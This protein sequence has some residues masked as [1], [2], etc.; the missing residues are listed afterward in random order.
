MQRSL[1]CLT[2]LVLLSIPA[3]SQAREVVTQWEYKSAT[4]CEGSNER[5]DLKKLGE[6]G[7]ELVSVNQG[8]SSGSSTGCNKYYFK[9]PR[10]A[11][12]GQTQTEQ[13]VAP[14]C[15]LS[16]SQIL[17]LRGIRI[18]MSAD[19]LLAL[20]PGS[21]DQFRIKYALDKA[22]L[23]PNYGIA[24]LNFTPQEYPELKDRFANVRS[25]D[26]TLFD[27]RVS[28]F[29]VSYEFHQ[30]DQA[31]YGWT[32]DDWIAKLSESLNLPEPG[33][34]DP[35]IA[36]FNKNIECRDFEAR[37]SGQSNS[38]TINISAKGYYQQ[39][40]QRINDDQEKRRKAIKP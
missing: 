26:I 1:V 6:E 21:I 4:D 7:W 18:G 10:K 24:S 34:W 15:N 22:A 20:F 23:P 8:V 13:P 12:S 9:R 27:G 32:V 31:N 35:P 40:Q 37:A 19:E 29:Y 38:T 28:A 2:L 5:L 14:K 16:L 11:S 39:V 25:F 36:S 17:P 30:R 3:F 33:A